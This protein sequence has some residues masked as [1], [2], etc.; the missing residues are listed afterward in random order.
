[1]FQI[2]QTTQAEGVA[3]PHL[4][5]GESCDRRMSDDEALPFPRCGLESEQ[6]T[7]ENAVRSGVGDQQNASVGS[8]EIP[9]WQRVIMW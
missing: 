9:E 8:G 2:A 3:I 1:M 4:R 7:N 6:M 5:R